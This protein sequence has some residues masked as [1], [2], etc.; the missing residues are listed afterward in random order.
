MTGF[1]HEMPF[2]ATVLQDG[3]VRFRLWAPAQSSVRLVLGDANAGLAMGQAEGGWF[4]HAAPDVSPGTSYCFELGDGMRV[5]DPASRS[6]ARDVH[7]PSLVVAPLSYPWKQ[8]DWRG[9]P[10]REAVIYEAHLGC[11]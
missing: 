11:F 9:R 1:A 6:Q 7:G 2:G 5:P 4:E 3:G 10:W 8:P